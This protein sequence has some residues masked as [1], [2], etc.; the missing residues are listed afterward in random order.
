MFS[1]EDELKLQQMIASAAPEERDALVQ[2][3]QAIEGLPPEQQAEAIAQLTMDYEG[4]ER[5]LRDDLETNY[6]MLTQESPQGQVAGN[7][8]FSVYVGANPL[9]HLASG[10]M[11]YQAGKGIKENREGLEELSKAKEAGLGRVAGGMLQK[12]QAEILR[13]KEDERLRWLRSLQ[14]GSYG[15]A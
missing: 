10:M 3:V 15:S 6:A 4:R 8:Q 7:N 12:T 13:D 2:S 11:K 1:P 5:S 14:H 9:E